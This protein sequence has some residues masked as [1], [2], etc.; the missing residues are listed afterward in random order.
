VTTDQR[1]GEHR[2]LNGG[3]SGVWEGHLREHGMTKAWRDDQFSAHLREHGLMAEAH[4]DLHAALEQQIK[5]TAQ[6]ANKNIDERAYALNQAMEKN[7]AGHWQS[8]QDQHAQSEKALEKIER[9]ADERSRETNLRFEAALRSV[10]DANAQRDKAVD[11]SIKRFDAFIA[12]NEGKGVGQAP[13]IAMAL[14]VLTAVLASGA[15]VIATRGGP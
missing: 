15:V 6:T 1:S 11:E 10:V 13:F 4:K 3:D 7:A 12:R 5:D 14:A 9:Y 8:H 2:R